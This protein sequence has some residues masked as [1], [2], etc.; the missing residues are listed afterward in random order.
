ME[1]AVVGRHP[2]FAPGL[3]DST[4]MV[5]RGGI[6]FTGEA[7]GLMNR[8]FVDTSRCE[9]I[10]SLPPK[11]QRASGKVR[12]SF[13]RREGATCLHRLYQDGSAK[14]RFPRTG[15]DAPEAVLINMAGG[16]TG[17]DIFGTEVELMEGA[18]ATL[19]TQ[20]CERIYRSTGAA[21]AIENRI[22]LKAGSRLDWLPQETI[23]F[24]GGRLARRLDA[25]LAGDAELLAVESTVFGR[26]AM[27]ETVNSGAFRD[28]WRIRRAGRLIFADELLFEG[29]IAGQLTR[30][31]IMG[32]NAAIATVLLMAPECERFLE[33]VRAIIGDAGGAS[34][35]D[36]KLLVRVAAVDGF[37]LRRVL[38]PLLAILSANRSLP[39]VWQ[40]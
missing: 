2:D 32:G 11:P 31:A 20:A 5:D 18:R 39:K 28:R 38:V 19:T 15:G 25:E 13:R 17:G 23:L 7:A 22:E 27:G 26:A 3:A 1:P 12:M 40:L 10:G 36:G 21:V 16:M 14:V 30:P 33:S 24:D 9:S 4:A 29:D 8:M 35:W 37:S 34:A 6:V